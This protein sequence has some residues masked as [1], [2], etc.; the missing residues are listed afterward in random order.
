MCVCVCVCDGNSSGLVWPNRLGLK[1]TLTTSLQRGKTSPNECPDY[2]PKQSDGKAT[3]IL[4][5]WGMRSTR[6][7]PSLPGPLYPGVVAPD[8]VL[9]MGQIEL[10]SVLMLN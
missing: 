8:R 4:E 2:D 1:N 5:L 10:N 6:L 9:P 3:V 7:L